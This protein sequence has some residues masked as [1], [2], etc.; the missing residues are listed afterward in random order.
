MLTEPHRDHQPPG[1]AVRSLQGLVHQA[2]G[3]A[4]SRT[5]KIKALPVVT[6]AARRS[7]TE[8]RF[9]RLSRWPAEQSAPLEE[10]FPP[11]ALGPLRPLPASTGQ[12]THS[13]QNDFNAEVDRPLRATDAP[14]RHGRERL[15]GG[16]SVRTGRPG[17]SLSSAWRPRKAPLP[18]ATR[19]P[20]TRTA[21][22]ELVRPPA[23]VIHLTSCRPLPVDEEA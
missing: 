3:P 4:V 21:S 2:T 23:L 16:R 6:F 11:T 22:E 18:T 5:D 10:G 15:D 20:S 13:R 12:K 1:G 14:S 9:G 7:S 17:G 8:S 19:T